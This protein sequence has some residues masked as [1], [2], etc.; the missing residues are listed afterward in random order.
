M[1]V[2]R[3][4]FDD[5]DNDG[6][7]DTAD[8]CQFVANADQ[9]N[10]DTDALGD[11]CDDDDDNDG[12]PDAQDAFPFDPTEWLD[13]DGDGIGNNADPDDDNDGVPDEDDPFP[14]DPFLLSRTIGAK[15]DIAGYS[16]AMVGDVNGDGY[17]DIL[18]GAPKT[19]VVLPP[20][21][22][23]SLDVGIAILLSGQDFVT[24]L[25]IFP[26]AAKGDEF[27]T[28]V[29]ALGDVDGDGVLILLS[30]HQKLMKWI[31]LPEKW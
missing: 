30:A 11:A 2:L 31:L 8:N 23:K 17:A 26:G 1:A 12:V 7:L 25:H 29:A 19:D 24:P 13:T 4:L 20:Q 22:K 28:A 18:V 14:L 15:G 21:T 6:I 27:G 9:M 16:V 5:D 10:H 3:Y